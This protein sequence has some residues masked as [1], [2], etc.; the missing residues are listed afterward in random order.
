MSLSHLI[1]MP[2]MPENLHL[3]SRIGNGA[4]GSCFMVSDI[5]DKMLALKIVSAD[6]ENREAES[7]RAFRKIP[8]HPALT[9]IFS[10]GKLPDG[11]FYYTMEL[12]DNAGSAEVYQAD[13][14]AYRMKNRSMPL[15]ELLRII[16]AAASGAKHLH[17]HGLFHGDIK[18]ENI[19]FVSGSPKL[20]DFGTL[21]SD[22]A[23]TAGFV[24]ENPASGA[25]R[26]CYA[27]GKTLYCAWSRLD[28]A[29]F[30]AL[31]ETFDPD[32]WRCVRSVY[33][34]ACHPAVRRRFA[35]ATAFMEAVDKAAHP[36]RT[37]FSRKLV[38]SAAAVFLLLVLTWLLF[39]SFRRLSEER[40]T[41]EIMR[42]NE[43]LYGRKTW[44]AEQWIREHPDKVKQ[45]K[46]YGLE[47]IIDGKTGEMEIR[48]TEYGFRCGGDSW[49]DNRC[50]DYLEI[51]RWMREH[52]DEVKQVKERG[53][54]FTP[55]PE[56]GLQYKDTRNG[57]SAVG[58]LKSLLDY[59]KNGIEGVRAALKKQKERENGEPEVRLP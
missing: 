51:K 42:R 56:Y 58:D 36:R 4:A 48:D 30:P 6:W 28:A 52:P 17:E 47:I 20:A 25:D 15:P 59:W 13:T 33:L 39:M 11:R 49:L 50:A 24:P 1:G 18:P 46:E 21:S 45:M 14:L 16:S 2:E 38:L 8:A 9:Q 43:V 44:R 7:I 55:D 32:E 5:T 35:S 40:Q 23:G 54:V 37:V 27:L 10:S 34:R 12:A 29:A 3:H 19:I 57:Y 31:P 53:I 22:N 26:D 41:A